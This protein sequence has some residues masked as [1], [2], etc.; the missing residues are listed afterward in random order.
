MLRAPATAFVTKK[1]F[2]GSNMLLALWKYET[3]DMIDII[4]DGEKC[5]S[6][7]WA[8]KRSVTGTETGNDW[9]MPSS[10]RKMDNFLIEINDQLECYPGQPHALQ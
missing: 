2:V 7:K 4:D 9:E 1:A 6:C 5:S 10:P 8:T 3:A